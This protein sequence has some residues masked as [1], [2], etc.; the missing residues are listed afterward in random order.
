M[1]QRHPCLGNLAL[2]RLHLSSI[3]CILCSP[4]GPAF[5]DVQHATSNLHKSPLHD[6]KTIPTQQ[7]SSAQYRQAAS[8]TSAAAHPSAAPAT[9]KAC[10]ARD[11]RPA[12]G[13]NVELA[14]LCKARSRWRLAWP[15]AVAADGEALQSLTGQLIKEVVLFVHLV[16]GHALLLHF[17]LDVLH[18]ASVHVQDIALN[19]AAAV[20]RCCRTSQ[21]H[22][23]NRHVCIFTSGLMSCLQEEPIHEANKDALNRSSPCSVTRSADIKMKAADLQMKDADHQMPY[24]I[25][26]A[27]KRS[28]WCI[29]KKS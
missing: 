10:A 28:V 12:K 21:L 19:G 1:C 18:S 6:N 27:T 2:C 15:G 11:A 16:C 26:S 9:A 5:K 22:C 4:F 14:L 7:S 24:T 13:L 3:A 25:L 20:M 17:W 29:Y 8:Q 23:V